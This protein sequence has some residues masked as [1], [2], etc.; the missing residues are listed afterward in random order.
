MIV[1][2]NPISSQ[3][4]QV[5]FTFSITT[6]NKLFGDVIAEH[7][8]TRR[9]QE[10]KI[11]LITKF[12]MERIEEELIEPELE[13]IDR[14]P[15]SSRKYRYLTEVQIDKPVLVICQ[16]CV[17]SPDIPI[18]FP[19]HVPLELLQVPY[20]D[21][22]VQDFTQSILMKN[23]EFDEIEVER[24]TQDC[25]VTYDLAYVQGDFKLSEVNDLT[26]DLSKQEE[27]S[28]LFINCKKD[29]IINLD[30]SDNVK[31]IAKVKKVHRIG[32]KPLTDDLVRKYNF[33]NT[34]TVNELR[35]KII[36]I[37]TFSTLSMVL[38]N[39]LTDFAM[40]AEHIEFDDYVKN[41]FLDNDLAPKKKKDLDA[42]LKEV[43]KELVKEYIL[44]II[45]LNYME[46]EP[47]FLNKIYEEYEFDKIVFNSPNRLDT[48]QE[49]V[50]KRI[51][52][53]RVLEY[54]IDNNIVN[55]TFN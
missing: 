13:R 4:Y 24:A 45:N 28:I 40:K 41:H 29:D 51:Y 32:V 16:F 5:Y 1:K 44:M 47:R 46:I 20:Q 35:Q 21:A 54:C 49:Y 9:E 38:I 11:K 48:Y 53:T 14:V 50:N 6:V 12:V 39:Y 22:V 15:I 27:E 8:F 17:L 25:I 10:K 52:E 37:F 23:K 31:V 33:L 43:T 3:Y 34:K 36:D 19:H 55:V 26:I 42:Y 18:R 2:E 30:E 7:G